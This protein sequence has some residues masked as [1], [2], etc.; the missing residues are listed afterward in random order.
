MRLIHDEDP[1]WS[2]GHERLALDVRHLELGVGQEYGIRGR[3][4]LPRGR[5]LL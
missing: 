1:I 5:D 3:R 4:K 2:D